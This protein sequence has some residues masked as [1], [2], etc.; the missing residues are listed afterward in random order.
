MKRSMLYLQSAVLILLL[1]LLLLGVFFVALPL[2]PSFREHAI[3]FIQGSN[4]TLTTTG[5]LIIFVAILML[6]ASYSTTKGA[7]MRVEM[8]EKGSYT[9]DERILNKLLKEYFKA[10]FD[11]FEV[12]GE[13][14]DNQ[15]YITLEMPAMP[16]IEQKPLLEKI[17]KE[18]ADLFEEQLNYSSPFSL[19][20]IIL[21]EK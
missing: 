6:L 12:F 7:F 2:S 11:H 21:D 4:T 13:F 20:A 17:E 19:S 14:H 18:L 10:L 16:F 9:I 8:G 1:L 15:I 3:A 5:I